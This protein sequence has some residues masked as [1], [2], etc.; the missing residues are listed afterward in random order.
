MIRDCALT[1]AAGIMMMLILYKTAHLIGLVDRPDSKLKVHK[2]PIPVIGGLALFIS[3]AAVIGV[4]KMLGLSIPQGDILAAGTVIFMLGITDDY[5]RLSPFPKLIIQ[6]AVSLFMIYR[7]YMIQVTIFPMWVNYMLSYLWFTGIMNSIN[8]LDIM[9]GLAASI[10]L[11]IA[12]T[13][14]FIN[15]QTGN[16]TAVLISLIITVFL[17]VFL[18]FNKPPAKAYLGDSGSLLIGFLLALISVQTKYTSVNSLAFLTPILIFGIPIYDT[19][20]VSIVR[21]VKGKNPLHGS[22][23]H[24]ALILQHIVGRKGFIVFVMV[25][26]QTC[27]SLFAYLSTIVEI[28]WAITIFTGVLTALIAMAFYINRFNK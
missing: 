24:F 3:I 16:E 17:P 15:L 20:F 4:R 19:F 1:I 21:L 27:L 22:P 11:I 13:L 18:L 5:K 8:L 10:S 12:A 6:S 25:L 7:G 14:L 28:H 23:D 2:R 26:M 9:D